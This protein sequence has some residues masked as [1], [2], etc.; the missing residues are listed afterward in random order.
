MCRLSGDAAYDLAKVYQSLCGYDFILID[1][2]SETPADVRILEELKEHFFSFVQR[3]YP[4]VRASDVVLIT[5]SL[6]F[7]LIPLHDNRAHHKLFFN[8]ACRLLQ[9]HGFSSLS[10]KLSSKLRSV[11]LEEQAPTIT[12]N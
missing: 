3:Y 10:P 1:R 7:S 2:V 12:L 5:A 9:Q 6:F 11:R 4:E 8:K